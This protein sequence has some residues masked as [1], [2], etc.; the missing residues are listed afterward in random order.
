M[1][2]LSPLLSGQCT[3]SAGISD[4]EIANTGGVPSI[5]FPIFGGKVSKE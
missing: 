1:A 3:H 5:M 2:L 4:P